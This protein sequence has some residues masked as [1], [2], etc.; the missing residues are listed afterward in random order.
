MLERSGCI[1]GSRSDAFKHVLTV[2]RLMKAGFSQDC[3]DFKPDVF[4]QVINIVSM[5]LEQLYLVCF[6]QF[7][8]LA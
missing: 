4:H 5:V 1:L 3:V 7:D 2:S 8:T 6:V